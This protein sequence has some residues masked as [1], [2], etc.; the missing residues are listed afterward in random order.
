MKTLADIKEEL[1]AVRRLFPDRAERHLELRRREADAILRDR[2]RARRF[3]TTATLF[4]EHMQRQTTRRSV[5]RTPKPKPEGLSASA[6][7]FDLWLS[8]AVMDLR[9]IVDTLRALA[10]SNANEDLARCEQLSDLLS[11]LLDDYERMIQEHVGWLP[12]VHGASGRSTFFE[13]IREWV[14]TLEGTIR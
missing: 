5:G 7:Q 10:E 3:P 11:G 9:Q 12:R 6:E 2:P 13:H 14:S 8:L 1:R 4:A